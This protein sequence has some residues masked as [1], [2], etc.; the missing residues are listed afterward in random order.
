MP[1]YASGRCKQQEPWKGRVG[2]ELLLHAGV[3]ATHP[4]LLG[5]GQGTC[6]GWHRG[7]LEAWVTFSMAPFPG[8]AAGFGSIPVVREGMSNVVP[9]PSPVPGSASAVPRAGV[10]PSVPP[11]VTVPRAGMHRSWEPGMKENARKTPNPQKIQ[12][13]PES[14]EQQGEDLNFLEEPSSIS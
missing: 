10:S 6:Q 2:Q 3:S 9:G 8:G 5:A 1:A 7:V 13:N 12:T 14:L 11:V 4:S